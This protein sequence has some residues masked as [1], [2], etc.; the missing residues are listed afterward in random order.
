MDG[1]PL[2]TVERYRLDTDRV[3]DPSTYAE[4]VP[5]E[6]LT[7]LRRECPVVWVEEPAVLG[8]QAGPGFWLVLRHADV[9]KVMSQPQLFSSALGATQIRDPA[10]PEALRYVRRMMLNMDPPEHSRLRRLLTKSFT[11]RA[12]AQLED[13][14]RDH[15]RSIVA[16]V[17]G[18]KENGRCDFAK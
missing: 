13:R 17:A 6:A 3:F 7:R 5:F 9:L 15:A 10:T 16:R 4:G 11:P 18:D 1:D 2:A 8:W 12:V 14:I